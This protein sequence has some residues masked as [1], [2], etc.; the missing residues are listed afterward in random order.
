[1]V[2]EDLSGQSP[3]IKLLQGCDFRHSSL[4]Y[5]EN[6][7]LCEKHRGGEDLIKNRYTFSQCGSLLCLVDV[8]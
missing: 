7:L 5:S 1:M 3:H 6:Y 4:S 8:D 2:Q